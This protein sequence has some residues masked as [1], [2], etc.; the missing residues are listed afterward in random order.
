MI[1][2]TRRQGAVLV[3]MVGLSAAGVGSLAVAEHESGT[4]HLC[5][6]NGHP[7]V[8]DLPTDCKADETPLAVASEEALELL[9]DANIGLQAQINSLE[10]AVDDLEAFVRRLH[11]N[12]AAVLSHRER[13]IAPGMPGGFVVRLEVCD[14]MQRN[15]LTLETEAFTEAGLVTFD[16]STEDFGAIVARLTNGE[17]DYIVFEIEYQAPGGENFVRS[18]LGHESARIARD[19]VSAAPGVVDLQG[20]KIGSI[21]VSMDAVVFTYDSDD[22]KTDAAFS[23]RVFFG[24][25]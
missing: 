1:Q 20:L 3:L 4:V 25:D 8:V 12:T 15:C 19:Q 9:Q 24:L 18:V 17:D 22:D 6:K 21:S 14:G 11:G 23:V 10:T 13:G 16:E 2:L 5:T 7:R